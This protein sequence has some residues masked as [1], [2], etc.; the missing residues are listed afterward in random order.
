MGIGACAGLFGGLLCGNHNPFLNPLKKFFDDRESWWECVIDHHTLYALVEKY[1]VE[2]SKSMM[3]QSHLKR[4]IN[5]IPETIQDEQD[6][7]NLNIER[8]FSG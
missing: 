4:V 8:A 7:D 2:I 3:V 1:N 6:L 5:N